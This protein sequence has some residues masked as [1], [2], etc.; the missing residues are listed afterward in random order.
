MVWVVN[1][2]SLHEVVLEISLQDTW[3]EYQQNF[4][5]AFTVKIYQILYLLKKTFDSPQFFIKESFNHVSIEVS[6]A[7]E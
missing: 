1:F 3:A 5:I 6:I 7:V 2:K 4:T